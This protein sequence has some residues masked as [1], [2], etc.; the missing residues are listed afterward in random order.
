M[1]YVVCTPSGKEAHAARLGSWGAGPSCAFPQPGPPPPLY[2]R[3]LVAVSYP[4]QCLRTL[5]RGC[6]AKERSWRRRAARG[7]D[8]TNGPAALHVG[9]QVG[10]NVPLCG[11]RAAVVP[12]APPATRRIAGDYQP[13]HR[14]RRLAPGP[15]PVGQDQGR[16]PRS[17]ATDVTRQET[18]RYG[19][20]WR[21]LA[22]PPPAPPSPSGMRAPLMIIEGMCTPGT[23]ALAMIVA[24]RGVQPHGDSS[25]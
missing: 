24:A 23:S 15:P 16:L 1:V 11:E 20:A 7:D 14:E 5:N 25:S 9:H 4:C 21:L 19:T 10:Q 18:H 2:A 17:K 8:E 3:T 13:I 6:P 12:L 22:G